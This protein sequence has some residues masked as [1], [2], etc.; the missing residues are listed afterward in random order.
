MCARC[1]A[2]IDAQP[3]G[4]GAVFFGVVGSEDSGDVGGF[5]VGDALICLAKNV[6]VEGAKGGVGRGK[7]WWMDG[8]GK[9]RTAPTVS[10]S[11]LEERMLRRREA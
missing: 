3:G 1:V 8:W 9:R 2:G 4:E 10:S 7:E 6:W 11:E 5:G